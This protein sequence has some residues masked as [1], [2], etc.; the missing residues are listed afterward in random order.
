MYEYIFMDINM[1]IILYVWDFLVV[2]IRS[3]IGFF[4]GEVEKVCIEFI[5]E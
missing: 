3:K 5:I 4:L 1:Y 2:K